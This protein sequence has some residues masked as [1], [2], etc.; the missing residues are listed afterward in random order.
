MKS[1]YVFVNSHPIQYFAPLYK[2]LSEEMDIEVWYCSQ[3]GLN[4]ELDKEFGEKIKWDIPILEGYKHFFLKNFSWAPSIYHFFGLINFGVINK[5]AKIPKSIIIVHGWNYLTNW[6]V[7]WMGKLLGHSIYLRAETPLSHEILKKGMKN[8]LRKKVLN[9]FLFQYVD[10]FLFI[11]HQNKQF[12]KF[13]SIPDEKLVF[14]P[15]AVDNNRFQK[16]FFENGA[17]KEKLRSDLGLPMEKRI[18]L[19]SGKLIPKKRPLDLLEAFSKIDSSN[20]LLIFMG[21]GVLREDME[22]FIQEKDLE[23]V[24]ITGFVNQ[25]EVAKYYAAADIFVMCS[26]VGETWGLSTNEAMNFRLP[27]ILSDL[28]GSADDLVKN[29][30]NG[31]TFQTG[32]VKELS[33]ALDFFLTVSDREIKECGDYSF[34]KV[35]EYSYQQIMDNLIKIKN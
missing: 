9:L 14:T 32:N 20:G 30:K 18:F 5:M 2:F 27:I 3:H 24:H 12:Y 15:Y 23:N 16:E 29:G 11:G 34:K 17:N 13:H 28:T 25:S 19:F 31:F 10:Y 35:N 22:A 4:E 1:K 21:D 7:I 6:L 33:K 26:T 8:L